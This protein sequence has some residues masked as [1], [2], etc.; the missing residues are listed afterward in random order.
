MNLTQ[1]GQ[2]PACSTWANCAKLW[3]RRK[4]SITIWLFVYAA[5]SI[6]TS[7]G[8]SLILSSGYCLWGVLHVLRVFVWVAFTF[9]SFFPTLKK[10]A[11]S[12]LA[13][14]AC[15]CEWA[16]E[17][18]CIVTC[19]GPG[20]PPGCSPSLC[21]VLPGLAP[22][23]SQPWPEQSSYKKMKNDL[24]SLF[25]GSFYIYQAWKFTLPQAR[26]RLH[27]RHI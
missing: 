21:L 15:R 10:M 3:T 24:A 26:T 8:P 11:L 12:E 25:Q 18:V 20:A 5:G 7:R 2:D 9:S 16:S 4:F 23:P 14:L 6:G 19:S 13:T 1:L 22:N 27:T 17:C